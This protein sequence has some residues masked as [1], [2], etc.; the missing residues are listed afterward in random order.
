M[1]VRLERDKYWP[2]L[3]LK[4]GMSPDVKGWSGGHFFVWSFLSS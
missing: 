3:Q 2:D 1:Q 4:Q